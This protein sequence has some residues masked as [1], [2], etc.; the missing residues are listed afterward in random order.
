MNNPPK[1]EDTPGIRKNAAAVRKA[2][3]RL[4][5]E[6]DQI[7]KDF[8]S[9]IGM[10]AAQGEYE[11]ALKAQQWLLE[12]I[13][14]EEGQRVLD[15]SIDKQQVSDGPRGPLIQIGIMQGGVSKPKE[16]PPAVTIETLDV[17]V[18]P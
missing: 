13:P 14:A 4:M 3:E 12:H 7:L 11:A 5:E 16:L 9:M 15:A 8:Q 6:A 17:E 10:A 18:L 1:L 2:R